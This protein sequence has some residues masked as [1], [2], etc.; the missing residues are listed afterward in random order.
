MNLT[1]PTPITKRTRA[2]ATAPTAEPTKKP[3]L[4]TKSARARKK[5]AETVV[6]SPMAAAA[7]SYTSEQLRSMIATTAYYRAASRHFAPGNEMEDW[8]VAEQQ[9]IAGLT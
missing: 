4:T 8:L 6:A 2:K 7:T 5:P 3:T 1:P 9:V